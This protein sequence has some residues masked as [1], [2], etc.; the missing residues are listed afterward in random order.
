[1]QVLNS[2][3]NVAKISFNF[4]FGQLSKPKFYF[5]MK[6]ASFGVLQYHVGHI[7]L[8]LVVVVEQTNYFGVVKLV[9]HIDFVFS[10]AA[11]YLF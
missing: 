7:F 11:M 10:I 9:M 5:V 1:M 8:L 2:F 4:I 6:C 3:A